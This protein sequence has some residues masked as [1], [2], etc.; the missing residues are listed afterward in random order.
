MAGA[1]RPHLTLQVNRIDALSTCL[2]KAG[3]PP[4]SL[5]QP[6][7]A[8]LLHLKGPEVSNAKHISGKS[9]VRKATHFAVSLL[10]WPLTAW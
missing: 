9:K 6:W 3:P 4:S 8:P 10:S 2:F 1:P 5:Y 7:L